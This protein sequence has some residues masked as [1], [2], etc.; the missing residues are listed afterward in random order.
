MD[1]DGIMLKASRRIFF[2]FVIGRWMCTCQPR[3]ALSDAL[4]KRIR[5]FSLGGIAFWCDKTEPA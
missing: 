4:F 5:P 2:S 3:S 1:E